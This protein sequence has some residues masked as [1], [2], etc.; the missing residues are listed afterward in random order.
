MSHEVAAR[1]EFISERL[2]TDR[3]YVA[4]TFG[5]SVLPAMIASLSGI[6][7]AGSLQRTCRVFRPVAAAVAEI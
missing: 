3:L 2:L 6:A 4:R 1:T 5:A 7:L